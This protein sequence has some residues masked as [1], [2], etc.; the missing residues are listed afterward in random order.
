MKIDKFPSKLGEKER[1]TDTHVYFVRGPLSQW[2]HSPFKA[3]IA[4]MEAMEYAGGVT[5]FQNCEQYMMYHK[6]LLMKDGDTAKKILATDDPSILKQL[7]REVKNY[8]EELWDKFR[9]Y[10]VAMGNSHKFSKSPFKE[11]LLSTGT[12]TLV[13]AAWYDHIW[14]VGLKQDDDSILDESNWKGTNLLGKALMAAREYLLNGELP[15]LR[16]FADEFEKIQNNYRS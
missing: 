12:R 2:F 1:V 16:A 15:Y 5:E 3:Q 9:F 4:F 13:E 8:D 6:A 11:Y 10:V 14:G 7:G